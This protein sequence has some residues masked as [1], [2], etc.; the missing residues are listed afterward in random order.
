MAPSGFSDL[1]GVPFVD[2]GRDPATGL[3]CWG[4]FMAVM[5]RFGREVKDFRISCF[6]SV[7]V[8]MAAV[9]E[10]QARWV[11]VTVPS[12]GDAVTMAIDDDNFPGMIQ[13]FGVMLDDVWFAHCLEKTG[14]IKTKIDHPFFKNKIKG[15]FRLK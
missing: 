7:P 10:I 9:D 2:G 3:D 12:A 15:F 8:Y 14:S 11:P 13:H 5:G 4:L 6:Q 1:I